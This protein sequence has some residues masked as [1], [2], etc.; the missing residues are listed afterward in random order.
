MQPAPPYTPKSCTKNEDCGKDTCQQGR[1]KCVEIKYICENGTCIYPAKTTEFASP[2][3]KC[4]EDKCEKEAVS[5]GIETGN[6]T[7]DTLKNTEY[8]SLFLKKI[9]KLTNSLYS[10]PP[11]PGMASHCEVGIYKDKITLGDLNNDGKDDAGVILDGTCGGS[12]SFR[13]LAITINQNGKPYYLTS[14]DLGDRVIIKSMT[15]ESGVITL[16]MVVHGPEDG[17]CCPSLEKSFK[18]KLSGNQL[19][20]IK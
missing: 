19:I 13:E 2:P 7:L 4:V 8:Y 1:D 16:D 18:Y 11:E 15:I 20:E 6:L 5:E 10:E 12:G 9:I 17:M 3:Y 14:K